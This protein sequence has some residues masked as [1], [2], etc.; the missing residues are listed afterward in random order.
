MIKDKLYDNCE[1]YTQDG[2]FVIGYCP[3]RRMDWYIAKGQ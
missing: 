3:K 1:F 2:K